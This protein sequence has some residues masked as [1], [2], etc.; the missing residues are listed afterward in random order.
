[1]PCVRGFFDLGSRSLTI[2]IIDVT[3]VR[4]VQLVSQRKAIAPTDQRRIRKLYHH[5]FNFQGGGGESLTDRYTGTIGEEKAILSWKEYYVLR[6][7][8][9]S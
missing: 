3:V 4:H 1:M 7:T 8:F 2:L 9:T 5:S 6:S